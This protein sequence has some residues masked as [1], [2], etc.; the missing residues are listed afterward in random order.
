ME[1]EAKVEREHQV[2][3]VGEEVSVT[4]R[5]TITRIYVVDGKLRYDIADKSKSTWSHEQPS[6]S[7]YADG[8]ARA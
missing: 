6:A 2:A 1:T 7:V 5:G 3:E 4:L 8:I